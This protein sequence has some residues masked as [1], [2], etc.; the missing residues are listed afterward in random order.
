MSDELGKKY[1]CFGEFKCPCC[2]KKWQSSRAWADDG[3]ECKHC[4]TNVISS[5]LQRLFVYIC[6]NCMVKWKWV[7]VAEGL[8]CDKCKSS[9]LVRPLDQRNSQD[10]E[11]IR[12][13]RLEDLDNIDDENY[14]DPAKEHRQDLCRETAGQEYRQRTNWIPQSTTSSSTSYRAFLTV[15]ESTTPSLASYQAPL[16]VPQSTTSSSKSY[17]SFSTSSSSAKQSNSSSRMIL[18][19]LGIVFLVLLFYRYTAQ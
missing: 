7:Y 14:I 10:R 6:H 12:A 18:I 5:N 17:R 13:H 4:A 15:P 8:Q 1:P 16:T 9:T 3:Q 11:F 2:N 19:L